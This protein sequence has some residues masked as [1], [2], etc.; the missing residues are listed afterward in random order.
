[1]G[2]LRRIARKKPF[3]V[4]EGLSVCRLSSIRFDG[5]VDPGALQDLMNG[6]LQGQAGL[7]EGVQGAQQRS[8]RELTGLPDADG[9]LAA[10]IGFDIDPCALLR[11]N[12]S[13]KEHFAREVQA[14][15]EV[16]AGGTRQLTDDDALRAVDDERAF[17]R[18]QGQIPQVDFAF[19]LFFV[20]LFEQR[21]WT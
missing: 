6:H 21:L 18:H 8:Q 9:D 7:R 20:R 3:S 13:E 2:S 12:G 4:R 1:M 16:D 5:L 10:V 14:V 15:F 17:V 11:D 19:D